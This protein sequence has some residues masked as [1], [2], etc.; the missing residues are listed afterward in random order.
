MSLISDQS[1]AQRFFG[2]EFQNLVT[3]GPE[4]VNLLSTVSYPVFVPVKLLQC[5]VLAPVVARCGQI[6]QYF[7]SSASACNPKSAGFW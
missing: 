1:P 7:W 3:R 4:N 2:L 6:P 5:G